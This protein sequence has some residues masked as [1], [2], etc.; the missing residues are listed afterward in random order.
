MFTKILIADD[1]DFNDLGAARVLYELGV[2][3]VL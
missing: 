3:E 2:N 1:I